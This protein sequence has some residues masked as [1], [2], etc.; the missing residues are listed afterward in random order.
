MVFT[1]SLH[2]FIVPIPHRPSSIVVVEDPKANMFRE[3]M[4]LD[5]Q[6]VWLH[7]TKKKHICSAVVCNSASVCVQRKR[8]NLKKPQQSLQS[9]PL[10]LQA[11]TLLFLLQVQAIGHP[12]LTKITSLFFFLSTCCYKP[13]PFTIPTL[14]I[15]WLY[16]ASAFL[17]FHTKQHLGQVCPDVVLPF[18]FW[19]GSFF[20]VPTWQKNAI[21]SI[22]LGRKFNLSGNALQIEPIQ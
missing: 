6:S 10:L 19:L 2:H 4:S 7:F 20:E 18:W 12:L 13:Q 22:W 3:V 16:F 5:G 15:A 11:H 9:S 21:S 17:E 1:P 8:L 14:F